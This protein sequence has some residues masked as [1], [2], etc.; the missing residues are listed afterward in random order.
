MGGATM[1]LN[2]N[3]HGVIGDGSMWTLTLTKGQGGHG[4][5]GSIPNMV[6]HT[7]DTGNVVTPWGT[8][9]SGGIYND[10]GPTASWSTFAGKQGYWINQGDSTVTGYR[11]AT[12]L[13]I[14]QW[15]T[16][17]VHMKA[18]TT[19][20][21][22]MARIPFACYGNP[23]CYP[24]PSLPPQMSLSI[25]YNYYNNFNDSELAQNFQNY[26]WQ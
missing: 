10:I 3:V 6:Y 12:V 18:G 26:I 20:V 21:Y 17:T 9:I 5:F 16:F 24:G 11:Y 19:I 25:V 8:D 22:E 13:G 15:W 2:P 23:S 7:M 14:T 4:L 1:A